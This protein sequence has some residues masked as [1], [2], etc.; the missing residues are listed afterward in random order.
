[1]NDLW[2]CLIRGREVGHRVD[3][4]V[5]TGALEYLPKGDD[6]PVHRAARRRPSVPAILMTFNTILLHKAGRDL[7][8]RPVAEER[9]QIQAKAILLGLDILGVTLTSRQG[10]VFSHKRID[11]VFE[12]WSRGELSSPRLSPEFEIPV[13]G[14]FLRVRETFLLR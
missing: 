14:D 8:E 6:L 7:G 5:P 3:P 9:N 10:L 12:G 2:G 13:F 4:P 11:R 1:M